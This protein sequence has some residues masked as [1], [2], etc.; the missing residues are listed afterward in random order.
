MP[1][2]DQAFRMWLLEMWLLDVVAKP[3]GVSRRNTNRVR[4]QSAPEGFPLLP[5]CCWLVYVQAVAL[6]GISVGCGWLWAGFA[7]EGGVGDRSLLG[8]WV[9]LAGAADLPLSS[10]PHVLRRWERPLCTACSAWLP[11][12]ASLWVLQAMG[13]QGKLLPWEPLCGSCLGVRLGCQLWS[14][15]WMVWVFSHLM[16]PPKNSLCLW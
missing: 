6:A 7:L 13:E 14:N 1:G 4:S 12:P 5:P 3:Q 8:P 15:L 9:Y 2:C 16:T 10:G 11:S